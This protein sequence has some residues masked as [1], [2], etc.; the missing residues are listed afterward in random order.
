MITFLRGGFKHISILIPFFWRKD[1]QFDYIIFFK[2]WML[3]P[4]PCCSP[5]M[6]VWWFQIFLIF[7]PIWGRFPCLTIFQMGWFNHQLVIHSA[8]VKRS[9]SKNDFSQL[10]RISQVQLSQVPSQGYP[11]LPTLMISF[12]VVIF[13]TKATID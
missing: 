1:F 4:P 6:S 11:K 5:K 13:T 9:K 3:Q 12:T 2:S 8:F 10:D 7:N